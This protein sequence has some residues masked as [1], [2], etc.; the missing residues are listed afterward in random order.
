MDP[1]GLPGSTWVSS[2]GFVKHN[3]SHPARQTHTYPLERN[4]GSPFD[5]S[6][7]LVSKT[8]YMEAYPVFY[9]VNTLYFR[10]TD[11]SRFDLSFLLVSKT[12]YM[13][14]YPSSALE[15]GLPNISSTQYSRLQ[16]EGFLTW[17]YMRPT[18]REPTHS[19]FFS[20]TQPFY[21]RS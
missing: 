11:G 19:F 9:R 12:I 3:K 21:T 15:A 10:N 1:S 16:S 2:P 14:A 8:I 17:K 13:E 6:F 4:A 20:R 18:P 7:L 5:L